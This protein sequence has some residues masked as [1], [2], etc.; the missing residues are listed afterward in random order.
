MA[1]STG[2]TVIV[3]AATNRADILDKALLRPGRFDRKISLDLPDVKGRLAILSVHA[4]KV[5]LAEGVELE[6]LARATPG[7]SGAELEACI[8]EAALAAALK[9]SEAINQEHLEEARDKVR[10]GRQK[11]GRVFPQDELEATAWHEAGHTLLGL[12]LKYCDPV[13]KVT[14]VPRGMALGAT[15]SLPERDIVGLRQKASPRQDRDVL[16]RSHRR[17]A[18]DLGPLDRRRQ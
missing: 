14:I 7:F 11:Q 8:N 17:G 9:D 4:K 3:M 18:R 6:I 2:T 10:W 16:W 13:H 12:R 15:M 1:F 5:K